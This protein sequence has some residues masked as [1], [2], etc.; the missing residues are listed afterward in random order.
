LR[1]SSAAPAP[2][3]RLRPHVIAEAYREQ[4]Y[5]VRGAALAGKA[6]EVLAREA[7]IP[8]RTLASLELAWSEGRDQ[9]YG[10]SVL[11]IDEAGMVD[12]R[13]LGR[14]LDHAE[15]RR[16]KV[17]L[18]GDPDLLKAI[19]AGDAYRG[20]L[21]RH[22]SASIESIRRQVEPWQREASEQLA[23]G[24]VA[25]ALD[26]YEAAGPQALCG[27]YCR[28]EELRPLLTASPCD[29]KTQRCWNSLWPAQFAGGVEGGEPLSRR[30]G[31]TQGLFSEPLRNPK[32][33]AGG[34]VTAD[35]DM[36]CNHLRLRGAVF[37]FAGWLRGSLLVCGRGRQPVLPFLK[38]P[39]LSG[40]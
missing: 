5:E 31:R 7:A 32:A 21:E 19:G 13:Q 8:S 40:A 16:A 36:A 38:K 10:G 37:S 18:L 35:F 11:M 24:R 15:Q 20:L 12:V 22:D 29:G 30:C 33:S 17:I 9:L 25:S 39:M 23:A 27:S 3:R 1:R 6:A 14:V 28:R 2:A 34:D 4:G 26:A